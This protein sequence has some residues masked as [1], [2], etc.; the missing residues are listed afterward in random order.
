M[1]KSLQMFATNALLEAMQ[2]LDT[3][4]VKPLGELN[5]VALAQHPGGTIEITRLDA[6]EK[7]VYRVDIRDKSG[8]PWEV[9]IDAASGE[10]LNDIQQD[11]RVL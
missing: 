2:L 9:D 1:H 3:A 4:K 8:Q 11:A 7:Y 10:V 6:D 5:K